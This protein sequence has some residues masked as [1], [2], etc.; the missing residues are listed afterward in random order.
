M[1]LFDTYIKFFFID[2]KSY[3]YPT[4]GYFAAPAVNV[5]HG[6]QYSQQDTLFGRTAAHVHPEGFFV[7]RMRFSC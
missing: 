6:V 1:L 5:G 4:E 2:K 7:G 3:T